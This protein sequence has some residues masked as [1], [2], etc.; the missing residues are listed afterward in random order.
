[1][2][3]FVDELPDDVRPELP[4]PPPI[5]ELPNIPTIP[6]FPTNPLGP[7]LPGGG[8]IGKSLKSTFSDVDGDVA[9]AQAQLSTAVDNSVLEITTP[10]FVALSTQIAALQAQMAL[11]VAGLAKLGVRIPSVGGL[12]GAG[13][14]TGTQGGAPTMPLPPL[15]GPTS[16][17]N[18]PSSGGTVSGPGNEGP[19]QA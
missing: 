18:G 7:S 8:S 15:G 2:I 5:P 12:P 6:S 10:K 9:K 16:G 17:N 1:M 19:I 14:T 13:G 3:K 11:V 4:T